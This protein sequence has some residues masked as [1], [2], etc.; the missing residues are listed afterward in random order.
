MDG[1]DLFD[2]LE[3]QLTIE[4]VIEAKARRAVETGRPFVRV[5]DIL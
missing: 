5:R 4:A 1:M 3:R 2:L